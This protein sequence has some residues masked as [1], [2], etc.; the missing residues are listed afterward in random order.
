[1]LEEIEGEPRIVISN[2]DKKYFPPEK[3]LTK[4]DMC[5]IKCVLGGRIRHIGRDRAKTRH[6]Y[7]LTTAFTALLEEM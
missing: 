6:N 2:K 5:Y 4:Q 3:K 7:V 1:V